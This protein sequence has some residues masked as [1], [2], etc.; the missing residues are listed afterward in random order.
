MTTLNPS[1]KE[2]LAVPSPLH[3]QQAVAAIAL[4]EADA[5]FLHYLQFF[6]SQVPVKNMNFLHVLPE[7]NLLRAFFGGG[8]E[9]M[10]SN[11]ELNDEVVREMETK[12]KATLNNSNI[13]QIRFGVREGNPLEELLKE[14]V[15]TQADLV[16]IGQKSSKSQHG[17]LARNL[18]RKVTCHALVVP[19]AAKDRLDKIMVPIDFSPN[20]LKAFLVAL[21]LK[22]CLAKPAQIICV[23]VYETPSMA[24]YRIG[25]TPEE[26]KAMIEEDRHAAFRDFL[27]TYAPK[28]TDH[29]QTVLIENVVGDIGMYLLD[30]AYDK[31]VDFIVTGAKG[32]SKVELLLLGSVTEHLLADNDAIPTLIVK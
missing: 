32:H 4:G 19:E 20:A 26:I 31:G 24:A 8:S 6:T 14:A 17:I 15:D 11:F 30:Y 25:K 7:F 29:I 13:E 12:I 3:F 1:M 9:S 10:I 2:H 28:E 5:D 21:A 23:N 16:L 18:A 22:K 27:R